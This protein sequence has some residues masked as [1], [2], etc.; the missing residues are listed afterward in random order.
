MAYKEK[1]MI[2]AASEADPLPAFLFSSPLFTG[3]F[4]VMMCAFFG[5]VGG[6]FM[7]AYGAASYPIEWFEVMRGGAIVGVLIGVAA[8]VVV[9]VSALSQKEEAPAL[10]QFVVGGGLAIAV[11]IVVDW[12]SLDIIRQRLSDMPPIVVSAWPLAPASN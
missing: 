12:L 1:P 11:M 10:F 6:F 2:D 7:A 8:L 3:F 9:A 4:A 5:A